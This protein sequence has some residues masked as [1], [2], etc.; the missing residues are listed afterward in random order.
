MKIDIL[1]I[2]PEFTNSIKE[3]S[4]IKRGIENNIIEINSVD[5]RDFTE[6]KHKKV[7]D[8]T[9]G[10]GPGMLMT[11]QPLADSIKSVKTEN[12]H[13]IYLSPR[14]RVFSQEISK[15]LS[16]YEHLILLCGHYEGIDQRIIDKYVDEELSI[17]DYVLTGGELGAMVVIDTTIR[18]LPGILGNDL[19]K[20]IESFDN[21][22]L[23]YDQYT[24]PEVFEGMRVPEVLL[25][26]N[27]KNIEEFR[28]ESR[29]KNTRKTR[30]ELLKKIGG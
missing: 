11:P 23:E 27:H 13:V 16:N 9:Y 20:D 3:Y 6:N 30:P 12:S 19:S 5:I 25:S 8:Y 21:N 14:G 17:G 4:M 10:G 29:I 24:R 2:F 22:L 15:E 18:H 28:K 7:D 1:T 26:G